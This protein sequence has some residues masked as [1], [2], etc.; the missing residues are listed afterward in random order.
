ME[1]LNCILKSSSN[2]FDQVLLCMGDGLRWMKQFEK[3]NKT[4]K[5]GNQHY[6]ENWPLKTNVLIS[7][8]IVILN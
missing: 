5:E 7:N 3:E 4:P 1:A 6:A 8:S 2:S